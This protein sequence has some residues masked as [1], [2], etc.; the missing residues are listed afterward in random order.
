MILV[1]GFILGMIISGVVVGLAISHKAKDEYDHL[2][3]PYL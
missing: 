1:T 3:S 2:E